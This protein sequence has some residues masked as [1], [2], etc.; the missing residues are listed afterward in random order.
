MARAPTIPFYHHF[1]GELGRL[2]EMRFWSKVD[3]RGH[4][5][6]WDWQAS[7]S[8]HGYGRFK[9]GNGT[10]AHSNRIA[11]ALANKA[12]PGEM[13]VLHGCDRPQCCN[14]KHLRLGTTADNIADMDS[15]GRRVVP[16]QAGSANGAAKLDDAT[17]AVVIERLKRGD[18]NK[19][20][21]RGL[22]VGHS[23][24]SRIRTGRSWLLQARALGWEPQPQFVRSRRCPEILE[25]IERL[26]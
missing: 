9:V 4:D 11:W 1:E 7:V 8:H 24:V 26:R 12:D 10:T 5:E 2:R 17:L 18:N 23:L 6:C 14:P 20:A 25:E 15:R 22:P 3:M 13:L 16:N 19:Q 21:A